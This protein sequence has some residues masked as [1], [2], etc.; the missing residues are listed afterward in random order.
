MEQQMSIRGAAVIAIMFF[1]MLGAV[2]E[3]GILGLCIQIYIGLYIGLY[4]T[5]DLKTRGF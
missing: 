3:V 2:C 5:T 1:S 4:L